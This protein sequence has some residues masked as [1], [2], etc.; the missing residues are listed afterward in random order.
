MADISPRSPPESRCPYLGLRDDPRTRF[1]FPSGDNYC[2][3]PVL[4]EPIALPHQS[5][6]CLSQN[7]LS[8]PVLQQGQ[9]RRRSLP[10]NIRR[11]PGSRTPKRWQVVALAAAALL[12]II[13]LLIG[14][15]LSW[16]QGLPQTFAPWAGSSISTARPTSTSRASPTPS[17]ADPSSTPTFTQTPTP[18]STQVSTPTFTPSPTPEAIL[19]LR[20]N[21]R[22]GPNVVFD[23][24]DTLRAGEPLYILGR[25][26]A[27]TW[28]LVRAATGGEGWISV[29]HS[30]GQ[31]GSEAVRLL[32]GPLDISR[33]PL[34]P[35]IP[36]T[37]EGAQ[38]SGGEVTTER[39]PVYFCQL[40]GDGTWEWYEVEVTYVDGN[41]SGRI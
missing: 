8:C 30:T 35:Y 18:T 15:A 9:E 12:V 7:Y 5:A 25:D 41:R 21:L 17:L 16:K 2:H 40:T 23:V 13:A 6:V 14:L 29:T 28:V 1:A 38:S 3:W 32:E 27:G 22:K 10:D 20:S 11:Q 31:E 39:F 24:I 19:A 34:A 26:E 4:A 37:P 36:P 33:I